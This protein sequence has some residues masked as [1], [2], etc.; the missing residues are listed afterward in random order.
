[1]RSP[2][3]V[4]LESPEQRQSPPQ[5]LVPSPM[6]QQQYPYSQVQ[7]SVPIAPQYQNPYS[8]APIISPPYSSY[9]QLPQFQYPIPPS[10]P[11]S[12]TIPSA[13]CQGQARCFIGMVTE[14]TDGDTLKVSNEAWRLALTSTPELSAPMGPE[15][16]AFTESQCPPGIEVLIDQ[17]DGQQQG[18]F[19]RQVGVVYCGFNAIQTKI[20]LN[21]LLL[22]QG[23]AIINDEF[24][25][26][27]EFSSTP[28]AIQYGCSQQ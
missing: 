8:Q 10:Q 13:G 4:P 18:S 22:Q 2:P 1:M 14:I 19:D 3:P 12:G 16:R 6:Q 17:D 23:L 21:E 24:C 5:S 7:P 9:N 27:S 15:A 26:E 11:P 20:S 28:W 25:D